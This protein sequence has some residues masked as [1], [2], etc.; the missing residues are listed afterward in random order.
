MTKELMTKE[1][2]VDVRKAARTMLEDILKLLEGFHGPVK[3]DMHFPEKSDLREH[4]WC[5]KPLI[6]HTAAEI[7]ISA[8]IKRGGDDVVQILERYEVLHL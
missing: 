7:S 2:L 4:T 1:R 3:H 8:V 5:R 6:E